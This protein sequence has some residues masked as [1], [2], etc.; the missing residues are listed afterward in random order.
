MKLLK[1]LILTEKPSVARDI[2]KVIGVPKKQDG[3][4]EVNNYVITWA[5]GHLV[6]LAAPES[7][8]KEWES[9]SM[10]HLPMI[11]DNFKLTINKRTA[12]QFKV[13]KDLMVSPEI[14]RVIF[15]TDAGPEGELIARW[16]YQKTNCR[17]PVERLWISSLTKEAI[18]DG[19]TNLRPSTE[20]DSLFHAAVARARADWLVGLNTTRAI[21]SVMKAKDSSTTTYS[22][23]RVQSP[24]LKKVVER[25]LEIIILIQKLFMKS[26]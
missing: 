19:L 23:G 12:K 20:F 2:A 22:C 6:S 17:K 24:T 21:T 8:K 13:V 16:I 1:T 14:D 4:Y 26:M 15:A 18:Q 7:Y 25:C 9:W 11:P 10:S 3:F 5:V